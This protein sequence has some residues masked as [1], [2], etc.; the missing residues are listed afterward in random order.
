MSFLSKAQTA[1]RAQT[2]ERFSQATLLAQTDR[3]MVAA[4]HFMHDNLSL[5]PSPETIAQQVGL[6]ASRF[7]TLFKE[8]TGVPLGKYL[9]LL[10]LETAR[11]LLETDFPTIQEVTDQV[12]INDLSH[13]NRDFKATYGVT[14]AQYRRQASRGSENLASVGES[15]TVH[16]TMT[17]GQ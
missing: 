8:H 12:G 7:C 11:T 10:R 5:E 6:S 1:R 17:V 14:P 15:L 4:I 13:F 2:R 9:K 16:Q 3:R